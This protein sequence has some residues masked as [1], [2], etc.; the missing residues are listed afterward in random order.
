VKEDLLRT[1]D[2]EDRWRSL[3]RG[4]ARP[5][6]AGFVMRMPEWRLVHCGYIAA[7]AVVFVKTSSEV[8]F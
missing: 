5:E 1:L 4:P 3:V 2:P 8:A 6:T 7:M